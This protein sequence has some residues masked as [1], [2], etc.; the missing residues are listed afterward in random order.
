[1]LWDGTYGF[2]ISLRGIEWL[3]NHSWVSVE[4]L[5]QQWVTLTA[6]GRLRLRICQNRKWADKNSLK[7]FSWRKITWNTFFY[8]EEKFNTSKG[9][10]W[11]RGTSWRLPFAVC[12]KRD[13][14]SLYYRWSGRKSILGLLA[15]KSGTQSKSDLNLNF[16]IPASPNLHKK[17]KSWR[18]LVAVVV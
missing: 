8:I 1:M 3:S 6:N 9:K 2:S 14:K 11:S 15:P 7:Q 16:V 12:C 4:R 13:S 18:I 5:S 17:V 10:T